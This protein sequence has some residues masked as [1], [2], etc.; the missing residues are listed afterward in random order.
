MMGDMC[1]KRSDELKEFLEERQYGIFIH[2]IASL[3]PSFAPSHLIRVVLVVRA[4]LQKEVRVQVENGGRIRDKVS[5]R[6]ELF[7]IVIL[8]FR[9]LEEQLREGV[10][11]EGKQRV[12]KRTL[13]ARSEGRFIRQATLS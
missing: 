12:R 13:R 10:W 11:Y 7:N 5:I 8:V 6:P 4:F 9:I 1:Q 3:Q 2:I